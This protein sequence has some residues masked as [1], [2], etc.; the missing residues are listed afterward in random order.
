MY[1]YKCGINEIDP[2]HDY[3]CSDCIEK[4]RQRINHIEDQED[5][6]RTYGF[7]KRLKEGRWW[8]EK[9]WYE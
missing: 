1:C 6:P 5:I 9:R 4:E 2:D 8:P 7:Y 3:L